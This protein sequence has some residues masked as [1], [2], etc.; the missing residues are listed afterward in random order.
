M[1]YGTMPGSRKDGAAFQ[2]AVG[3]KTV[4]LT[5]EEPI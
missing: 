4:V 2:K 3:E 5:E 1:H